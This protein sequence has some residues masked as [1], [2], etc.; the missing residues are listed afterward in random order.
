MKQAYLLML[1]IP[2]LSY[3]T[4]GK[5]EEIIESGIFYPKV[6]SRSVI[7]GYIEN[8]SEYSDESKTIR[9]SVDEIAIPQ[10]VKYI[11]NIDENGK[12]MFD[13]PLNHSTNTYLKYSDGSINPYIFPNDTLIINCKI[14]TV[15]NLIDIN[16]TSYDSKHNKFQKEITKQQYWINSKIKKLDHYLHDNLSSKTRNELKDY[17]FNFEKLLHK[18]IKEKALKNKL[19][20]D[21]L[22]LTT[23]Y[24][25]YHNIISLGKNIKNLEEKKEFFSFLNDSMI[26]NK[27]ALI[28][29]SYKHFLNAYT[30]CLEPHTLS[31]V[32]SNGKSDE[33]ITKEL[34]VI[35]VENKMTLRKGLWRDYLIGSVINNRVIK[36]EEEFTV[37]SIDFFIKLVSEKISD[38]YTQ[39]LL[40]S[41]LNEEKYAI[42]ERENLNNNTPSK[43]KNISL[44]YE[45]N[46]F[47]EILNKNKG[48]VIYLDFWGTWCGACIEQFPHSKKLHSKF[49]NEEVSFVFL[50]CNSHT[51]AAKNII[52]KHQLKGQHYILNQKQYEH[53]EKQ[54]KIVGLPRYVLIDK[55]GKVYSKNASRPEDKTTSNTIEKLL[56]EK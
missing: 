30:V 45:N 5:K 37:Q 40:F 14:N 50:C 4:R 33:Q 20:S 7:I 16:A 15:G 25:S 12:F 38:N 28:T 47:D 49:E 19:I 10:Q 13:I 23:T 31:E 17:C 22:Q 11:T 36:K 35:D 24:H 8:M 3:T 6:E 56:K 18:K 2:L 51:G 44:P 41:M 21:Y 32:I 48:K 54:F 55:Q 26:F 29:S 46:P 52:K 43:L 42:N 9:L 39:Q 53:F 27:K 1:L 34:I